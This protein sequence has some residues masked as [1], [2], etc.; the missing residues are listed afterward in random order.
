MSL[1]DTGDW[2]SDCEDI[3]MA[4]REV[5]DPERGLPPGLVPLMD[6]G[7][8]M[9]AFIDCRTSD[10]QMWDWDPNLC[11][12]GHALAPLE[13]TLAEWLTDWLRGTM[14]DGPY[15]HR[16]LAARGCPAR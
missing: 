5:A 1:T 9:W 16:E 11:C 3:A 15:T 13:Q 7:C 2:F 4:Y 10:G 14:P 12:Q 6:R 8:A